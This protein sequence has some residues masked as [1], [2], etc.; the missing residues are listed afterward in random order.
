MISPPLSPATSCNFHFTSPSPTVLHA[1]EYVSRKLQRKQ[2]HLTFVVAGDKPLPIGQGCKLT[3]YPTAPARSALDEATQTQR[4]FNAIARRAARKFGLSVDWI[5]CQ[6]PGQSAQTRLGSWEYTIRRSLVQND[7]L[8]SAESLTLLN[9]DRIYTLKQQLHV[10]AKGAIDHIPENVYLDSCIWLLRQLMKETSGRPFSKGFFHCTYDHISI[11]D[12]VLLRLAKEYYAKYKHAA[13][14]FPALKSDS[15]EQQQM[16]I[17]KTSP[18]I[19]GSI[20]RRKALRRTK[21]TPKT[22]NSASEITPITRNEWDLLMQ[23]SMGEIRIVPV[24]SMQWTGEMRQG[25]CLR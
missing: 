14:V 18:G 19:Y 24:H 12:D 17:P 2:M 20:Q 13:I 21:P 6:G 25:V 16:P 7:V 10:L 3:A 23:I 22:P 4:A 1:L 11:S 15:K 9:I 8:F 5:V